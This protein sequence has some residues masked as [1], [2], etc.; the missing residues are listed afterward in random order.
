VPHNTTLKGNSTY[1]ADVHY[2]KKVITRLNV[3]KAAAKPLDWP[4]R[5]VQNEE[6]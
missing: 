4:P 6:N 2:S 5:K 3:V 1:A